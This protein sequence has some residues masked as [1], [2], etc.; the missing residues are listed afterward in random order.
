MKKVNLLRLLF[1]V[2][3]H[4]HN[5]RR[6]YRTPKKITFFKLNAHYTHLWILCL[7]SLLTLLIFYV[8][9][10]YWKTSINVEATIR[11]W[12]VHGVLIQSLENV[13]L[14]LMHLNRNS[15]AI[16]RNRS[17]VRWYFPSVDADSRNQFHP[18][19]PLNRFR[20]A[21]FQLLL[22]RWCPL[23]MHCHRISQ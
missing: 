7:R 23:A 14:I 4:F 2:V 20:C 10:S 19:R 17:L 21:F 6:F 18:L 5:S 13:F 22:I 9:C 1:T 15:C 3:F 8:D 12:L 11:F 16:H